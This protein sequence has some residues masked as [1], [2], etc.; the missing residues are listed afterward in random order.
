M[1]AKFFGGLVVAAALFVSPALAQSPGANPSSDDIIKALKPTGKPQMRGL[2][3]L[4]AQPGGGSEAAAQAP[5]ISL[6]VQF[7]LGSA[8]LTPEAKSVVK[9]L[10]AAINSD[11]LTGYKF[12]VEGHTDSTGTPD[13]NMVLSQ[14]RANAVR[15]DL[16]SEYNVSGDRLVAVGKG[17]NEPL[18]AANPEAAA[19]RRVQIVNLGASH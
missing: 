8:E 4:S 11:Q 18:D 2:H 13:G 12:Q 17:Q 9:T 7:M 1:A 15:D 6:N 5:A 16:I 10:A 19:N 14:A 3:I